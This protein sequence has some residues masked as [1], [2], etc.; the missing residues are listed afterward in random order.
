LRLD[1][2]YLPHVSNHEFQNLSL[3]LKLDSFGLSGYN[4]K[5]V[6]YE[7]FSLDGKTTIRELT[8]SHK[9]QQGMVL[10][11][12]RKNGLSINDGLSMNTP[13]GFPYL[14][15]LSEK[16][17]GKNNGYFVSSSK[18]G[19][20]VKYFKPGTLI[21]AQFYAVVLPLIFSLLLVLFTYLLGVGLF[22]KSTAL[23]AAFLMATN[24]VSIFVS[25][26]LWPDEIAAVFI[27]IS[28]LL[29]IRGYHHKSLIIALAS[30]II[31]GIALLF[32]P[33]AAF[34]FVGFLLFYYWN[35]KSKFTSLKSTIVI[36]LNP[37]MLLLMLGLIIPYALWHFALTHS[38]MGLQ[39]FNYI[40][41]IKAYAPEIL[42]I[43]RPSAFLLLLIGMPYL[44]PLF[45]LSWAL[46]SKKLRF[47][48]DSQ[49]RF[50]FPFLFFWIFS[51]FGLVI[52]FA[53]NFEHRL[54][55]GAYPAIALLSAF[56]LN[57][58]RLWGRQYTKNWNWIGADELVLIALVLIARWSIFSVDAL[59]Y[60]GSI[61][62]LNP[63]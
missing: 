32:T 63:F 6:D 49:K 8:V 28:V 37:S 13:P 7:D 43:Q 23:V 17:M 48:L 52:I 50:V 9:N 1:T 11:K 20:Q 21:Y 2:F 39:M 47:T 29:F 38:F 36:F 57:H 15:M 5:N 22:G 53:D 61:L 56:V 24:P 41:A 31:L 12:M 33:S 14:L 35:Q 16:T 44:S 34:I 19:R 62:I 60:E 40:T 46:I 4:L 27:L 58:T 55:M 25:Q 54:A 26:K 59:I 3:A 42:S 45:I 18:L 10:D 30:G 51:Y